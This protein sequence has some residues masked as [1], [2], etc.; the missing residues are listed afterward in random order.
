MYFRR[1]WERVSPEWMLTRQAAILFGAAAVMTVLATVILLRDAIPPNPGPLATVLWGAFGCV[2]PLSIFFLW[3]GMARFL[4][5]QDRL[6]GNTSKLIRLSFILGLWYSAI[7]YY[8]LAYLPARS[9]LRKDCE[10]VGSFPMQ[11]PLCHG[12]PS[13]GLK[14]LRFSLYIGWASLAVFV[15]GLFASRNVD[16][17]ARPVAPYIALFPAILLVLTGIYAIVHFVSGEPG[18]HIL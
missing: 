14:I 9:R 10:P 5:T 6:K 8:L 15:I 1:T 12:R 3:S 2:T 17:L 11:S 7:V 4:Q 18:R 16:R 13:K